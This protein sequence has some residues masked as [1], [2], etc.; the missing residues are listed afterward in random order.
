MPP[1]AASALGLHDM[2][3]R[4][5]SYS[6]GFDGTCKQGKLTRLHAWW[7]FNNDKVDRLLVKSN[8]ALYLLKPAL[9]ER[10]RRA[11]FRPFIRP[12]VR[13]S[14]RQHLSWVSCERKSSLGWVSCERKSSLGFVP[15]VM[16][17]RISFLSFLPFSGGGCACGLDTIVRFF[18]HF[19]H[20]LNL[21]IFHPQ[22]IDS[23][24][25]L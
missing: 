14:I 17:L 25:L 10:L 16:K 15:I 24:Y 13:S 7:H 23:W 1:N 8:T 18:C 20:I 9:A 4:I 11:T 5:S 12:F 21:V 22:Y 6:Q 2:L 19:F 3:R